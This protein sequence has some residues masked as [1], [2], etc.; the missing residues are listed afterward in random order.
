MFTEDHL[1]CV[2]AHDQGQDVCSNYLSFFSNFFDF[3]VKLDHSQ[4]C[5]QSPRYQ[6]SFL[7]CWKCQK[8]MHID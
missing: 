3:A 1:V 4:I 8:K 7:V 6:I 5:L 2:I